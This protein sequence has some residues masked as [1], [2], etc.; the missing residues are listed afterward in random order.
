MQIIRLFSWTMCSLSCMFSRISLH[1]I[2]LRGSEV[3]FLIDAE[4]FH[5]IA[6]VFIKIISYFSA[7]L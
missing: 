6:R 4:L 1:L 3:S 7:V 5:P 2:S